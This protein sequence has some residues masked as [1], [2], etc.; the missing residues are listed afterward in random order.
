MRN[1]LKRLWLWFLG[2]LGDTRPPEVRDA[3]CSGLGMNNTP[4]RV[5][6][7]QYHQRGEPRV[8]RMSN[9]VRMDNTY[10][11]DAAQMAPMRDARKPVLHRGSGKAYYDELV[12]AGLFNPLCDLTGVSLSW[13]FQVIYDKKELRMFQYPVVN[14][15]PTVML[16]AEG[17]SRKVDTD[18]PSEV[19]FD[20]LAKLL[21]HVRE[22]NLNDNK[23][24]P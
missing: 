15:A 13:G 7:S 9:E 1:D 19:I 11:F 12:A 17:M 24:T 14:Y 4:S 16:T 23:E 22:Q 5:Q 18:L 20:L 10:V 6:M 8:A 3:P 21:K 2:L